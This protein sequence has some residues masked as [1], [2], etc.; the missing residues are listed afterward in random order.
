MR[1]LALSLAALAALASAPALAAAP[2]TDCPNRDV[3]FS[4]QSPLV[5]VL[6]SPAARA[7]VEKHMPGRLDKLPPLFAGT[8]PPTFAAILTTET[9]AR[10]V[11]L[12][13]RSCP[14]STNR[15]TRCGACWICWRNSVFAVRCT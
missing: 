2:V 7:V 12:A 15:P 6:L 10:F 9:A 1:Q 3:P 11:G 14:V 8:T 4:A 5:D 13:C